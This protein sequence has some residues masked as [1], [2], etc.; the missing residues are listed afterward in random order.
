MALKYPDILEHNNPN[1]P[2]VDIT[3]LKGVAYP[4]GALNDTGSI[5]TAKRNPGAI[6][7]LTGSAQA[8]YGFK[9]QDSGSVA[10]DNPLNWEVLGSGGG[11]VSTGSLLTT[12]SVSLNTLTF[13]KGD[14]STFALTVDTGSGG[15]SGVGFPFTGS[16]LITGSL[17]ITGSLSVSGSIINELTSSYAMTA[18]FADTAIQLQH[19]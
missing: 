18:S 7:F 17:G 15:G 19:L 13:T 9:G 4:I 3:S 6:V 8:S 2:L 12:G 16:A 11:S 1:L 14:G 5:P 10:W